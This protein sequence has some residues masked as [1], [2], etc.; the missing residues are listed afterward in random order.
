ML[1]KTTTKFI[2]LDR[3]GTIIKDKGHIYKV[4]DLE[5][6]PGAISGLK[7]IQEMGYKLIII[8]NQAGIARGFYTQKDTENFN[9]K[10]I[11]RLAK[12]GVRIEKIYYCPHHLDFTGPCQCRKPNIE[13]AKLAA[14]ELDFDPSEA[15]FIGDKD[16]DIELGK[17]CNGLTVL[18]EN[19]Q[20][21]NT[22]PANYKARDLYHA[23]KL[24]RASGHI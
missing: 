6:L 14:K 15:I 10:L 5:F 4:K 24:L 8:T 20:Y 3:D 17:N 16:S 23:F 19:N 11:S 13:L 9:K 21:P 22:V 2:I 1:S 7:K 12:R 18:I